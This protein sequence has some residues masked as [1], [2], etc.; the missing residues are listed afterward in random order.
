[1]LVQLAQPYAG[2]IDIDTV[3]KLGDKFGNQGF[4]G[5]GPFCWGN[6]RPVDQISLDR[7]P[8]YHWGPEFYANKGPALAEHV[9][10]KIVP[11]ENSGVAS[12]LSGATDVT[13]VFPWS[14]IK[15][16]RSDKNIVSFSR[17]H[18]DGWPSSA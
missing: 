9:I 8:T 13:N 14:A 2:V 16:A 15:T 11:E 12:I 6:W 4:N 10:W 1:M 7:H 5:T 3:N 17:A 18:L